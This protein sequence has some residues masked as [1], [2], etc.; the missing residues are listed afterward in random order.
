MIYWLIC[1][2]FTGL[3][4]LTALL[5]LLLVRHRQREEQRD[6]IVHAIEELES[7][8]KLKKRHPKPAAGR[9]EE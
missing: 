4:M 5:D 9:K 6:L 2:V 1:F 3:A 7:D 8:V